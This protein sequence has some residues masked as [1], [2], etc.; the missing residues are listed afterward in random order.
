MRSCYKM[1][2]VFIRPFEDS[3]AAD[4]ASFMTHW[5]PLP[6]PPNP[7]QIQSQVNHCRNRVSGEVFLAFLEQGT[8]RLAGYLQL[9]ELS[10]VCFP[11]SVEIAALLVHPDL[12]SRG[13]GT[14]LVDKA[15]QWAKEKGLTR[16]VVSSMSHRE[17]AHRFYQREGFVEWKRSLF[18]E[19]TI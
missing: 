9:C 10:L 2:M 3:D 8:A 19:F 6:S 14:R 17:A 13:I 16:I 4:L 1:Q 11:P 5:G 12:R 18:F 7:K 15:K